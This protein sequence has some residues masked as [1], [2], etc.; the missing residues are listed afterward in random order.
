M[1]G[2]DNA[3]SNYSLCNLIEG[4]YQELIDVDNE[5]LFIK[6]SPYFDNEAFLELLKLNRDK[7]KILSLN[8]QSLNAKFTELN[9]LLETYLMQNCS[10]QIICLQETWLSENHDLSTIQLPGYQLISQSRGCSSHGGVAFYLCNDLDFTILP[11]PKGSCWDGLFIEITLNSSENCHFA[12]KKIIIGNIYR[13]PRLENIETFFDDIQQILVNLNRKN[14]VMIVGDFNFDLLKFSRSKQIDDF[15]TL[16]MTNGYFPKITLP[17]RLTYRHGTLID[18]MFHKISDGFKDCKSGILLSGISDHFPYFTILD[19]LNHSN[20]YEKFVVAPINY[21]VGMQG[22]KQE[23]STQLDINNSVLVKELNA[24]PNINYAI[25]NKCISDLMNKYFP[26]KLVRFRKYKHKRSPWMTSGILKSI[27]YRDKLYIKLKSMDQ[28]NPNFAT[29]QTNFKTYNNILKKS[30]RLA[31]KQYYENVFNKHSGDM[32]KTWGMINTI[33]NRTKMKSK[34]PEYFLVNGQRLSNNE[35]LSNAFNNY[36]SNIGIQLANS[37]NCPAEMSYKN[38]LVN[39]VNDQFD[40]KLINRTDVIKA[41]ESLNSKT[42]SGIDGLSTV[43]LKKIKMEICE[44]LTLIINQSLKTG[45]FPDKLKVARVIPLYKCKDKK[46]IS[47]YRPI[48]MLPSVSKVFERIMHDQVYTYFNSRNLFYPSQYGFRKQR[49]TEMAALELIENIINEMDK[50]NIPIN[51]FLDLSKAFDT[52]DHEILLYK[53]KYYGMKQS[54]LNL[55]HSYLLNRTQYVDL[56]GAKSSCMSLKVGVPQG[57]ILGPLLFIIYVNDL[58]NCTSF[59][60]P[61]VY[62]DDTTLAASLNS[63]EINSFEHNILLNNA[64]EKVNNWMKANKLSINKNK[65]KAMIFHTPQRKVTLPK[66]KIDDVDIEYVDNFNFLG[67]IIDKHVNWAF[68]K[69]MVIKRMSKAVG[70]INKLKNTIP[71]STLLHIYN[72]LVLPHL[73][74]GLLLWGRKSNNVF[75]IQKRAIRSLTNGTYNCHTSPIFKSLKQIK[76]PDLYKLQEYKLCHNRQNNKLPDFFIQLL[77]ISPEVTHPYHTRQAG[78]LQTPQIFH[79]FARNSLKYRYINTLNSMPDHFRNKIRTHSLLGFKL[80]FKIVTV[81]S[82]I[83]TCDLP[84]CYSCQRSRLS[85]S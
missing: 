69:D 70:V 30:I 64:L 71:I 49:S 44:S 41:I 14:N 55:F 53:L 73:N 17:T 48:S 45:I 82:Y 76:L 77:P 74:Y 39:P 54:A 58:K 66:I 21:D 56:H 37:V 63:Y 1:I 35:E 42:S 67:I 15:L 22:F 31:K 18:N 85:S 34:F 80:Y 16:L 5:P 43:M 75:I 78:N 52:L 65:T 3:A 2:V 36:F 81:N 83:F 72:S 32:K 26:R 59:F 6:T 23:L 47:N 27:F 4:R 57:S 8:C 84:N 29:H 60:H 12:K 13:P 24:D 9:L 68:H 7:I 79:E 51:I 50:N 25:F 20:K 40:F 38:F 10:P 19:Y 46:D 33:L 61:I 62:A 28:S 11:V